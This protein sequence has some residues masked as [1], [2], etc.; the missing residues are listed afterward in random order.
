MAID[1]LALCIDIS[2]SKDET[3]GFISKFEGESQQYQ[4]LI[5][6][7]KQRKTHDSLPAM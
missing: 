4:K 1:L 7:V 3:V 5:D 6:R 2:R